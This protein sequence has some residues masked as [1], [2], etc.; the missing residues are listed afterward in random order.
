MQKEEI[1]FQNSS[2]F[3]GMTSI[4]AILA[5][6]RLGVNDRKIEKIILD[7]DKIEKNKKEIGYLRAVSEEKGFSIEETD[8]QTLDHMTLGASHGGIVAIGGERSIL[9][10][11]EDTSLPPDGFFSLIQGIEDPYNFGYAL[12][13]L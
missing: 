10:F 7:R 4:R 9:P 1:K 12:R 13:S 8:A 6:N 5:G 11:R 3:E 2:V